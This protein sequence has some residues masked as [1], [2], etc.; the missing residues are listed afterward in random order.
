[1][2]Y[3]R[4]QLYA[5]RGALSACV[6]IVNEL[7]EQLRSEVEKAEANGVEAYRLYKSKERIQHIETLVHVLV[8]YDDIVLKYI[9]TH[10]NDVTYYKEKLEVAQRYVRALG[11]DWSTVIWGRKSDY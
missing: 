3:Y 9:E 8:S 5:K 4:D 1:M 10:P 2:S 11:G 6:D 7:T